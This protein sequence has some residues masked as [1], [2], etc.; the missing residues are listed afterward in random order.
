M[1]RI[2]DYIKRI[3]EVV[4][5]INYSS[6]TSDI[7]NLQILIADDSPSSRPTLL[8]QMSNQLISTIKAYIKIKRG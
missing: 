6:V 8:I 2:I 5:S 7:F 1:K 4:I 3:H